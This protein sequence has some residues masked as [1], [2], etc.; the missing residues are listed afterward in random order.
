M[1]NNLLDDFQKSIADKGIVDPAMGHAPIY[2]IVAIIF[3]SIV[4][5]GYFLYG[6]KSTNYVYLICGII[7]MVFP[8]FISDTAYLII[9][10][11]VISVIPL[12]IKA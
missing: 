2:G 5:F 12:I 8:Y 6:K 10:G 7:L 4:G 11:I 1:G 9:T 3:F